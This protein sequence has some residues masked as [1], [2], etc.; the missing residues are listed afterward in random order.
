MPD[1]PLQVFNGEGEVFSAATIKAVL[2][3]AENAG[4]KSPSSISQALRK[5]LVLMKLED[6][7]SVPDNR[8]K[9]YY[10]VGV[11]WHHMR[12]YAMEAATI[13]GLDSAGPMFEFLY[14]RAFEAFPDF[15][16]D[17]VEPNLDLQTNSVR[18]NLSRKGEG[19]Y[20]L[21]SKSNPL[22]SWLDI[23]VYTSATDAQTKLNNLKG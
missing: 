17:I 21:P 4:V 8:T 5:Q 20:Q 11:A 14:E 23:F 3:D 10:A 19:H 6:A 7:A 2:A 16:N 9:T 1:T 18:A 22:V 15:P 12:N 13:T